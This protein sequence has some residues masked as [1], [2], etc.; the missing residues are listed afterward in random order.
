ML[1][2]GN[3]VNWANWYLPVSTTYDGVYRS[4][5]PY[6]V[7]NTDSEAINTIYW[8]LERGTA[9]GVTETWCV[10]QAGDRGKFVSMFQNKRYRVD[11]NVPYAGYARI[12]DPSMRGWAFWR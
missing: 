5:S 4:T 9:F 7:N 10:N 11:P 8:R 6:I 2:L 1:S 3:P 12:V